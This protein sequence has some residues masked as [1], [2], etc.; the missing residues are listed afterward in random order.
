MHK[1]STYCC[2]ICGKPLPE[3]VNSPFFP[4]CSKRCKMIDLGR[5]FSGDY[6]IREKIPL[7][8]EEDDRFSEAESRP[9]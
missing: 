7:D 9:E 8:V 3:G 2:R 1:P 5:W 4:F 6:R